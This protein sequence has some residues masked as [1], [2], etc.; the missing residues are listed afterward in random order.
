MYTVSYIP[1]PCSLNHFT[2]YNTFS[3]RTCT[4]AVSY[5]HTPCSLNHFTT[6]NTFSVRTWTQAVSYIHTTCTLNHFTTYNKFSVRTCTQAVSY[7]HKVSYRD[8]L[9]NLKYTSVCIDRTTHLFITPRQFHLYWYNV[10]ENVSNDIY[11]S[12][13]N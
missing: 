3:V 8:N 2:T 7:I 11:I 9:R 4:Q 5:V 6:Y 1:T 10:S 12:L 13:S